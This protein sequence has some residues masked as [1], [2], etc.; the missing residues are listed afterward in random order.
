MNFKLFYISKTYSNLT[1]F[2]SPLPLKPQRLF[3]RLL[4]QNLLPLHRRHLLRSRTQRQ[5]RS[6]NTI[7][8]SRNTQT[9]QRY[10]SEE[11]DE[12]IGRGGFGGGRG[13]TSVEDA[14]L[15]TGEEDLGD[16]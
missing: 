10:N 13:D 11:R 16:A 7:T 2:L 1:S 5:S 8:Q 12:E 4:P 15:L 14:L 3:R 9:T 6:P